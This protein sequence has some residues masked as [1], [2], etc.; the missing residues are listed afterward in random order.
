MLYHIRGNG[1]KHFNKNQIVSLQS[2][3]RFILII[4]ILFSLSATGQGLFEYFKL[5]ADDEG[6]EKFD[7]I[8]FDL[9]WDHWIKAPE[10]IKQGYFCIGASA[11]L[12][13]D[14]PF[15]KKSNLSFAYGIGF[16]SHNVHSNGNFNYEIDQNNEIYTNLIEIPSSIDIRKNKVSFSFIEV[17]L[18][19]RM[20][21]M[22]KSMEERRG[23]NFRLYLGFKGGWMVDNHTKYKDTESKIKVFNLENTLPYRYGPTVRIGFNKIAFN[24]FYSLSTVFEKGKGVELVPFSIGLSWMRF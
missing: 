9:N 22:N 5:T 19:F 24:A 1:S 11:Y 3:M 6:P 8:V 16:S 13:K 21:T 17:P 20:R 15:G 23:F 10:G 12:F 4:S 18:E 14:N 7:R 2:F